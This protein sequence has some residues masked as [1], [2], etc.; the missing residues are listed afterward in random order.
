[1]TV[2]DGIFGA[3]LVIG[4]VALYLGTKDRW[5]WRRIMGWLLAAILGISLAVGLWVGWQ[6]WSESRPRV[7]TEM[8]GISLGAKQSDVLFSKGEPTT[9]VSDERWEY[10]S[11]PESSEY[12][13]IVKFEDGRVAEILSLGSRLYMPTPEGVSVYGSAEELLAR[14]GESQDTGVSDDG[15]VRTYRFREHNL[16]VSFDRSGLIGAGVIAPSAKTRVYGKQNGTPAS[17]AAPASK[18]S[19]GK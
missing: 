4:L 16:L 17:A 9:R 18:T 1:M 11:G 13:V 5:R 15:L 10:I 3:A 14:Y 12:A 6:K 19:D 7:V 2:G 8:W